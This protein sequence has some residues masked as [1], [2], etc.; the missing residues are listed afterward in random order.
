MTPKREPKMEVGGAGRIPISNQSS[1][2]LIPYNL[3]TYYTYV[4]HGYRHASKRP[5]RP[6]KERARPDLRRCATTGR[7]PYTC[8]H[9]NIYIYIYYIY[10]Y[11]SYIIYSILY[12]IYYILD[13][14]YYILFIILYIIY[15][16][17]CIMYH[18]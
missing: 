1:L 3:Y 13:I 17:L 9:Y 4:L 6:P 16:V 15:Y 10:I 11:I 2:L 18:I 14:I 12:I 5:S 8:I 7:A